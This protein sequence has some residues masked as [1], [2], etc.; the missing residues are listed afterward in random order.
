M[1]DIGQ[2]LSAQS[3]YLGKLLRGIVEGIGQF[4]HLPAA[5][6]LKTDLILS[7]CQRFCGFIDSGNGPGDAS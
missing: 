7:L 3:L 1:G 5:A 2:Q 4:C 6:A